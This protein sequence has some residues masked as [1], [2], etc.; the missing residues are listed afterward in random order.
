M[1]RY[2]LPVAANLEA[3]PVVIEL[4]IKFGIQILNPASDLCNW[5]ATERFKNN[6]IKQNSEFYRLFFG[7]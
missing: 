1:N 7:I 3:W 6:V 5:L 4:A 2:Q